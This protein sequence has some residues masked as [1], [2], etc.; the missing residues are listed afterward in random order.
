LW[1][2]IS[3]DVALLFIG[4]N[5]TNIKA[6]SNNEQLRFKIVGWQIITIYIFFGVFVQIIRNWSIN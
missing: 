1:R 2:A 5:I 3:Y 4:V 6:T